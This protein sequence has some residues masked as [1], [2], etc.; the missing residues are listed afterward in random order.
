MGLDPALLR[1]AAPLEAGGKESASLPSPLCP[2]GPGTG[3]TQLFQRL[4]PW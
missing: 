3:L 1:S 4:P 2:H